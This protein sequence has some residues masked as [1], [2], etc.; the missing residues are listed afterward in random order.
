MQGVYATRRTFSPADEQQA[1]KQQG[2]NAARC[3]VSKADRKQDG[4]SARSAGIYAYGPQGVWSARG[5]DSQ[6]PS[7]QGMWAAFVDTTFCTTHMAPHC[8][9]FVCEVIHIICRD[10]AHLES[11]RTSRQ[12]IFSLIF[13][14]AIAIPFFIF[15]ICDTSFYNRC[16]RYPFL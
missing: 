16:L 14:I 11:S 13:I 15:A 8:V 6:M 5:T 4:Q 3:G 1:G 9:Q 12:L 10:Q 2:V 7:E